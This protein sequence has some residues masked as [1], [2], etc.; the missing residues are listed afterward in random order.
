VQKG[1]VMEKWNGNIPKKNHVKL[2][3]DGIK[4]FRQVALMKNLFVLYVEDNSVCCTGR[5]Q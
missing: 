3:M 5:I 4:V 1:F 2:A